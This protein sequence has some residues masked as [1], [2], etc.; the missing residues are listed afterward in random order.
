MHTYR[1]EETRAM[2]GWARATRCCTRLQAITG[3][4]ASSNS[5]GRRRRDKEES[6]RR[7]SKG[8]NWAIASAFYLTCFFIALCVWLFFQEEANSCREGR[9][10]HQL[11]W[12]APSFLASFTRCSIGPFRD[13]AGQAQQAAA[14]FLTGHR[15]GFSLPAWPVTEPH[16]R[17]W[18][19]P[20]TRRLFIVPD[21]PPLVSA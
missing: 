18:Y 2:Q 20:G 16:T 7:A 15:A 4:W 9:H 6:N 3:R 13:P 10:N 17:R 8:N 21:R 5:V 19:L 11:L 14:I 1:R 12:Q